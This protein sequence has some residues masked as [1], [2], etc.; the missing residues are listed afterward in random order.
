MQ[1]RY[2]D[3]F[4]LRM[5][6][7]EWPGNGLPV[8]ALHGWLDNAASF[9][10]LAPYLEGVHLLALDLPGHGHSQHLPPAASY[11]LADNCRWVAA[12]ADAM[13]WP[14]FV[15]LGHSMGAAAAAIT[16]AAMSRRVAGLALIDGL[17]PLAFTPEQEVARL[18]QLFAAEATGSPRPFAD[19]QTAVKVRQK[20]GRF[21]ITTEAATLIIERGTVESEGGFVW[22]HDPRLKG[23]TTHYYDEAQ[24]EAVLRAIA[25]QTLL[26][27]AEEGAFKAWQGFA[28]RKACVAELEHVVLPGRHHL[29]MECP[30]ALAEPLN[31][32]F[33]RMMREFS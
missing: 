9:I 14:R 27:S 29:H 26:I 20:A 23:P 1:Q 7:L 3:I 31:H 32:Y 30:Q 18:Q 24:A 21:P 5:A 6:A 12:L 33:A 17:G 19:R 22:R 28:R 10:P 8:I 25:V 15:L 11:H 16:A 4:G 13:G 2:F